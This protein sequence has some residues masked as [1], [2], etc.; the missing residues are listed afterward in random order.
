MKNI[1][2]A[3]LILVLAIGLIGCGNGDTASTA[4][5][6]TSDIDDVEALP[7]MGELPLLI[8]GVTVT[9]PITVDDFKALGWVP[10]NEEQIEKLGKTLEVREETRILFDKGNSYIIAF[11]ANLSEDQAIIVS[12]GSIYGFE[13]IGGYDTFELPG[14]IVEGVSTRDEVIAAYGKSEP[15]PDEQKYMKYYREGFVINLNID[16]NDIFIRISPIRYRGD[17]AFDTV[18]F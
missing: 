14:G 6:G 2:T 5:S 13:N 12:E 10:K 7:E 4:P 3:L 16:E 18:S 11:V 9:L 15:T 1:L 8:D 17:N